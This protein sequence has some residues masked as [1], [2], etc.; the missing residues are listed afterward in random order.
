MDK[1]SILYVDDERQN[2]TA[3]KASF[4]KTYQVYTAQSGEEALALL[5]GIRVQLIIADQRMP[6]MTGVELFE[7]LIPGSGAYTHGNDWVWR[8]PGNHRCHQQGPNLLLHHS[9]GSTTSYSL[10]SEKDWKPIN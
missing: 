6:G 9:L 10:S 5:Q 1:P 2:L 3:F 7:L 8:C 4:R